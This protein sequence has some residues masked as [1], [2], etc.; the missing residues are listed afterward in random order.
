[1]PTPLDPFLADLE[2]GTFT[3]DLGVVAREGTIQ[4]VP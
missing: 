4:P 3:R 2:R 1:M